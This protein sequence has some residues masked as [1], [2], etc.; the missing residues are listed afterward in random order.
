MLQVLG[1]ASAADGELCDNYVLNIMNEFKWWG[2][3]KSVL[4]KRG[5]G[6]NAKKCLYEEAIVVQTGLYGVEVWGI[7][8]ARAGKGMFI[9]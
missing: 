4:T 5:F 8:A 6:K 7:S 9:K 2:A 3:L 1:I